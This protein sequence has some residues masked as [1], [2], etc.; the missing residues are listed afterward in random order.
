MLCVLSAQVRQCMLM[1]TAM[2]SWVL[3][4]ATLDNAAACCAASHQCGLQI[5]ESSLHFG[6]L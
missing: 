5:N 6:S 1:C 4:L 3:L 2:G